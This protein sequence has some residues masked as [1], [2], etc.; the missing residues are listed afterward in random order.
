MAR[1]R[2]IKP[3]FWGHTKVSRI[4]RDARLLFLGLLNESDDEGRL[5]GS[6][7]RLAGVVFPHDDDVTA[8]KIDKWL[9]ELE[10]VCLILR[11]RVEGTGY[12]LLPGFT[13]HQKV[14]HP[15]DSRL[16]N[17][18]RT[19]PEPFFPDLGREQGKEQGGGSARPRSSRIPDEFEVTPEMTEWVQREC[20]RIDW[21]H[22]TK[23]FVAHWKASASPNAVKKDWL[24]AWRNWMLKEEGG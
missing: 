4:S 11:Y 10:S 18:S 15:T 6:P 20:P 19:D 14:S 7:K 17:P 21:R 23:R 2:T 13:E 1:I 8:K 16:P 9:D 24:Q 12:I 22:Q 5:L 3:E